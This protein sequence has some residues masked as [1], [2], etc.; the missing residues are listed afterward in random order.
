VAHEHK[1]E[2]KSEKRHPRSQ[3]SLERSEMLRKVTNPEENIVNTG[4]MT[5]LVKFAPALSS[6]APSP[7]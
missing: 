2:E 4:V 6:S 5:A 3:R 1:V 7:S